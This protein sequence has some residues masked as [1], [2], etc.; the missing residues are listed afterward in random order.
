MSA[1]RGQ[2]PDTTVSRAYAGVP[3]EERRAQRYRRLLDAGLEEIGTRGYDNVT[4][5]DVC[6]RARLTER[7][8]YEHFSDR[9]ALLL[10]VYDDVIATVMGASFAAAE[11]APANLVERARAGITAFIDA[12]AEDPRRARIQLLEPVGRSPEL[13]R[14]RLEAMHAFANTSPTPRS[15]CSRGPKCVGRCGGH[16]PWPWWERQIISPSS[17]SWATST[18]PGPS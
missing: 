10:A 9:H 1:D 4:V 2:S 18:S 16:L 7:Y 15:C 13:E 12:L 5:K 3:I 11:A 14:R 6:R 17:G 8:F